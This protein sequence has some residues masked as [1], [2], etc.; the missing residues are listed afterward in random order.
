MRD[1]LFQIALA[2]FGAAIGVA[3]PLL[4]R[5]HQKYAAIALGLTLVAVAILWVGYEL[6]ASGPYT[7]IA[8]TEL[9]SELDFGAQGA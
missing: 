6:A 1:F 9:A 5:S 7:A 3:A 4:K 8:N 2:L